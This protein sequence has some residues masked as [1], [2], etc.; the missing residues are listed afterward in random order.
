MRMFNL[1]SKLWKNVRI[2][3]NKMK[4]VFKKFNNANI[5]NV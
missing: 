1:I 3:L 2:N 5:I 4:K